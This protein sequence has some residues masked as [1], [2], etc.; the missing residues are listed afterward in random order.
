MPERAAPR[1]E[2]GAGAGAGDRGDTVFRPVRGDED[3]V[4][5]GVLTACT[6][7][8]KLSSKIITLV[9]S[10]FIV[11]LFLKGLFCAKQSLF[12]LGIFV[13]RLNLSVR[14]V[15]SWFHETV[16]NSVS[17]PFLN[18]RLKNHTKNPADSLKRHVFA[19][20]KSAPL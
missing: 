5:G 16:N 14:S 9:R 12:S 4:L 17:L 19:K 10:F 15:Y 11:D 13:I 3:G 6:P 1:G 7:V 18:T 8:A 2:A 20:Q